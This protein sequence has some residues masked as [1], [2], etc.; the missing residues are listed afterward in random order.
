MLLGSIQHNHSQLGYNNPM[1]QWFA[2]NTPFLLAADLDGTL[3]GDEA[4]EAAL[5]SLVESSRRQVILAL[6]SG[7]SL[8]AIE[9]LIRQG[10]LPQPDYIC[11]SVG[12]DVYDCNDSHN[13]LG[14]RYADQVNGNW[15]LDAINDRQMFEIGLQGVTPSNALDELKRVAV[16]SWHY[17]SPFP[18]AWGVLDGQ[19][20]FGLVMPQ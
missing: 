7:R 14:K 15:N 4:G 13:E 19:H 6:V 20:H 1:Q 9:P 5:K 17:H 16:Q 2:Q 8:A 12:T 11:G 3:L 18:N 10:R